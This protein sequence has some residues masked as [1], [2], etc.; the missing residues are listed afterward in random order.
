[1]K[2]R[3]DLANI[4]PRL[5]RLKKLTLNTGEKYGI[6]VYFYPSRLLS[7]AELDRLQARVKTI[8][9]NTVGDLPAYGIFSEDLSKYD[10]RIVT[11]I[12]DKATQRAIACSA[13]VHFR[14]KPNGRTRDVFHLGLVMIDRAFQRKHLQFQLYAYT[15]MIIWAANLFRPVWVSSVS[16]VPAIIGSVATNYHH[17]YP[18]FASPR[19]VTDVHVEI[20]RALFDRREEFGTGTDAEFDP[21]SFVIKNS[22]NDDSQPLKNSFDGVAK[23]HDDRCNEYCWRR[24]DYERGDEILQ[25]GRLQAR[26]VG[27]AAWR[28]LK[29]HFAKA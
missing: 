13:M 17:V 16:A 23:F 6:E 28:V 14:V 15:S 3:A 9:A 19:D 29:T 26:C 24:L 8:G 27:A 20:A 11:L 21:V 2:F 10:D 7:P 1:M 18:H 4:R 25:V 5:E 12:T 22:F